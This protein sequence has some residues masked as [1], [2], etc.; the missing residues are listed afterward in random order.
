MYM[1]EPQGRVMHWLMLW[2]L[3]GGIRTGLAAEAGP[4]LGKP[5]T[6]QEIAAWNLTV[7]ADGRGLP[8]GRGSVT[9]G[10]VLYQQRCMACHGVDG[11][12][13]SANELAGGKHG[14][15]D[16]SPDK[17]IGSY[18]PYATTLFDF[19]RRAMPLDAP[20][21]LDND[22]VYALCAYLLHLNKLLPP[23]AE[24]DAARLGALQMPNR[25]GFIRMDAQ[26]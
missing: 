24:L 17:T 19:I 15:T 16:A 18:W 1:L 20:G 5:A 2:M 13:G 8:P 22:Q 26:K 7:F 4:H 25:D 21:S 9:A 10:K 6:A 14:L 12:G 11:E 23:D 3:L